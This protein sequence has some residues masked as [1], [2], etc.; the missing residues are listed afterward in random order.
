MSWYGALYLNLDD[1]REDIQELQSRQSLLFLH[2]CTQECL[3]G[4]SP[5]LKKNEGED[6]T[7]AGIDFTALPRFIPCFSFT[8]ASTLGG[9]ADG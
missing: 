7:Y 6:T 3:A 1:P 8:F 5:A 9:H 2:I 4:V